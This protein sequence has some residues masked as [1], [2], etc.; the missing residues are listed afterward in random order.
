MIIM[1]P[2]EKAFF[3]GATGVGKSYLMRALA[4]GAKYLIVLDPKHDFSWSDS[5]RSKYD[6]VYVSVADLAKNWTGP[7][8]A[9]YRPDI[10]EMRNGCDEFFKWCWDKRSVHVLID[11]LLDICPRG[12]A[13]FWLEKCIKQGRSRKLTIWSGTQRP[14]KL[15]LTLISESKHFFIG[16]LLMPQDKK[17]MAEIVH[18]DLKDMYIEKFH[19]MYGGPGNRTLTPIDANSLNIK[20]K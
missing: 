2:G 4:M 17:R 9:I 12:N 20:R 19:F 13:G 3:V 14:T 10:A 6:D 8:P 1:L 11:E 18:P 5:G 16:Q 7:N 15:P